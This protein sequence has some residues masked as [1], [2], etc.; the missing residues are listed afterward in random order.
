MWLT[1][2]RV[3]EEGGTPRSLDRNEGDLHAAA[4]VNFLSLQ[5]KRVSRD[6]WSQRTVPG[7][8]AELGAQRATV[9][10]IQ[11]TVARV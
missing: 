5:R 1:C 2:V 6:A 7:D 10:S 9:F 4:S 11:A 8:F 3:Y